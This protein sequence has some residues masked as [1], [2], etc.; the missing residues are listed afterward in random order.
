MLELTKQNHV[1]W[2]YNGLPYNQETLKD[3]TPAFY[4]IEFGKSQ[5]EILPWRDECINA[6]RYIKETTKLPIMLSMSGGIDS[7]VAF[8]SLRLAGADFTAVICKFENNYNIDDCNLAVELCKQYNIE[9]QLIEISIAKYL[10][11]NCLAFG[12]KYKTTNCRLMFH[13]LLIEMFPDSYIIFAGGDLYLF[14]NTQR[15]ASMQVM[16]RGNSTLVAQ[17]FVELNQPSCPWFFLY[18]PEMILSFLEHPLT[19]IF[20]QHSTSMKMQGITDFKPAIYSY[21]WPEIDRARPKYN[22]FENLQQ[23]DQY[24]SEKLK[25]KYQYWD[26]PIFKFVDEVIAELK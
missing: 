13:L 14:K 8:H 10:H 1:K 22:G 24:Y 12:E 7:E 4:N 6:A 2:G 15:S 9:Y 16:F 3:K 26:E 23:L 20:I 17:K 18:T 25:E 21:S 5:S 19:K 11:D